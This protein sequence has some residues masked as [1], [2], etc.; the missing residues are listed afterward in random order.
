MTSYQRLDQFQLPPN[1]R[2]R[3]A[4]VTQLWWLV[5]ASLF[6]WSPQFMYG[7]RC[8]LLRFFGAKIGQHTRVRSSVRV[9]YPWKLSI[10]DY[11]WIGDNV[12]LYTLGEIEIGSHSVISQRCYLCTGSHDYTRPAFDIY[13]QPIYIAEQ[14]WLASD[15]FVVP[16]VTI[17]FGAVVGAR[18]TVL[19]D[20]PGGMI[21]YGNPA[22]PIKAR[23]HS[24]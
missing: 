24:S 10:G 13:E 11:V 16:G 6:A 4:F 19:H 1:F 22:I 8:W 12:E 7:W 2:G 17:G 3:S 21:C 9:T 18:S 15:V 5:Q 14:V 23:P 20:L